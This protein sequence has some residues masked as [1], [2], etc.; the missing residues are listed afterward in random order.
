M[1]RAKHGRIAYDFLGMGPKLSLKHV[2]FNQFLQALEQIRRFF[3]DT[4]VSLDVLVTQFE[5]RLC[6]TIHD[7]LTGYLARARRALS[8]FE[9]NSPILERHLRDRFDRTSLEALT[10]DPAHHYLITQINSASDSMEVVRLSTRILLD[11]TSD[12]NKAALM[13][14]GHEFQF[15][16]GPYR[17]ISHPSTDNYS[18]CR[19]PSCH[20][21]S[22]RFSAANQPMPVEFPGMSRASRFRLRHRFT[23]RKSTGGGLPFCGPSHNNC[24]RHNV[25]CTRRGCPVQQ[26]QVVVPVPNVQD[27]F[28]AEDEDEGLGDDAA[29]E[30]MEEEHEY[31][32]AAEE[33][34][35]EEHE[36]FEEEQGADVGEHEGFD[37]LE[38]EENMPEEGAILVDSESSDDEVVVLG[39]FPSQS[40]SL[41]NGAGPSSSGV[42]TPSTVVNAP[43]AIAG[44]ST[45]SGITIRR[46]DVAR[47]TMGGHFIPFDPFAESQH[48]LCRAKN[49]NCGLPGCPVN[50]RKNN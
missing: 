48:L 21:G 12:L 5:H 10:W 6:N 11:S 17:R 23:G 43:P 15:G 50:N 25:K 26:P 2:Y 30:Q 35:E 38:A 22:K 32:E 40:Q 46:R 39:V 27:E 4:I 41:L 33:Q 20:G 16:G 37:E 42:N 45:S 44:P 29:E 7:S 19:C 28:E 49:V 13:V 24:I 14:R 18:L 34:L 3:L 47:K 1:A 36:Y 31:F 9:K 8:V